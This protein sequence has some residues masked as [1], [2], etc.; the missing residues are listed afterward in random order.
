LFPNR[1]DELYPTVD[2]LSYGGEGKVPEEAIDRMVD[3]LEKQ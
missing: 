1:G 2:N 3:D